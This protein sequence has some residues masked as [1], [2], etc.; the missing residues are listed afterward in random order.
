MIQDADGE[1]VPIEVRS[2]DRTG[3]KSLAKIRNRISPRSAIRLSSKNFGLEDR[4]YSIPLYAAFCID[5][6]WA[7]KAGDG[8]SA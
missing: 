3:S 7:Q 5:G 2:G 6:T 1:V 8:S 4:L